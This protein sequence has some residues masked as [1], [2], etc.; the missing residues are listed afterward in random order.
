MSIEAVD[1]KGTS[2]GCRSAAMARSDVPIEVTVLKRKGRDK[3]SFANLAELIPQTYVIP[4]ADFVAAAPAF[5]PARLVTIRWVFDG[6]RPGRWCSPTW[7]SPT[8]IRCS[9]QRTNAEAAMSPRLR[10]F[11]F[12][13]L[14]ASPAVAQQAPTAPLVLRLPGGTRAAGAGNAFTAGRGAEVLFY[15]P[16]QIGILRGTTVSLARFGSSA[17]LGTLSTVGPF[18]KISLGAGIQYRTMDRPSA[19]P[20]GAGPASSRWGTVPILQPGRLRGRE[21]PLSRA[22]GSASP[23][24]MSRRISVVFGMTAPRAGRRR[25]PGAR[26]DHDRPWR[27]QN[28]GEGIEI[29][30]QSA[31]LPTRVSLGAISPSIL[32][33]SYFDVSFAAVVSRE[34]D[35]RIAP[36]A[37]SSFPTSRWRGGI[38]SGGR[39]PSRR[40][41]PRPLES[42]SPSADPL[43]STGSGSTM[44]SSPPGDRVPRIGSESESN[45]AMAAHALPWEPVPNAVPNPRKTPRPHCYCS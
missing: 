24:S 8:S 30:G 20:S 35:G 12:A 7:D 13:A 27:V 17:T 21:R 39:E 1:A 5:D 31:S 15:N 38:S 29:L 3:S 23:E 42:P 2:C 40:A 45:E 22:S 9:S 28:I 18:G 10:P 44:P 6:T 26:P 19:A 43:A 11:L 33:G 4:L 16:A 34:R 14:L 32:L 41:G 25:G 37:V 36:G